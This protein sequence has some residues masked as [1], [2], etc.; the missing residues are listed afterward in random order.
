[1]DTAAMTG[2]KPATTT[3]YGDSYLGYITWDGEIVRTRYVIDLD[4][5][6]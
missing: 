2:T 5:L 1:M 3:D 6:T 4:Y